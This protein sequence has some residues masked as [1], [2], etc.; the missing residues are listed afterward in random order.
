[1]LKKL[2]AEKKNYNK[3]VGFEVLAA[4]VMKSK[5]FWD[6]TPCSPLSCRRNISTLKMEAIFS[7]VTSVD[8]QRTTRRYIPEDC[9]L[10]NKSVY[11][12]SPHRPWWWSLGRSLKCRFLTQHWCG[13]WFENVLGHILVVHRRL[14]R[15][16]C[17][18]LLPA[19]S[20]SSSIL[21][22]KAVW[23]SKTSMNVY[24]TT[25]RHVALLKPCFILPTIT[26]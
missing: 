26:V 12:Y 10:Y 14:G 21:K 1:M 23:S 8:T 7:S 20:A 18:H 15:T 13:W 6:I 3:P 16:Y 9:T 25:W 4:V 17:F 5:I 24:Q 19:C 2:V 22:M 11:C